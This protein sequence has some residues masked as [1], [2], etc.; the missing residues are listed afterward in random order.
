MWEKYIRAEF[1]LYFQCFTIAF[2]DTFTLGRSPLGKGTA[3][4]RDLS[5]TIHNTHKRQTYVPQARFEPTN[6]ASERPQTHA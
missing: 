1:P 5:L 6:P 4:R 3:R 2:I